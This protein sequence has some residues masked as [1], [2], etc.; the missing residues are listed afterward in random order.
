MATLSGD[1]KNVQKIEIE[2]PVLV[3]SQKATLGIEF[4]AYF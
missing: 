4:F 2:I 3:S 1:C